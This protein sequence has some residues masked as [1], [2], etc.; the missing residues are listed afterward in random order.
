LIN[1]T[2]SKFKISFVSKDVIKRM[3]RQPTEWEKIFTIHIPDKGINIQNTQG[4]PTTQPQKYPNN[5]IQKWAK[6]LNRHFSK[7]DILMPMKMCSTSLV[8][9]EMQ[10]KNHSEIPLPTY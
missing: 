3:K 6:G 4:T 9:K 2:A 5:P 10:I 8:I 7:E 1:W